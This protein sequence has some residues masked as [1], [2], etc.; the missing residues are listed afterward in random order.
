MPLNDFW[1]NFWH[2]TTPTPDFRKCRFNSKPILLFHFHFPWN[3]PW[4]HLIIFST[5]FTHSMSH[6]VFS[7]KFELSGHVRGCCYDFVTFLLQNHVPEGFRVWIM[8]QVNASFSNLDVGWNTIL[9]NLW[10]RVVGFQKFHQKSIKHIKINW[11][12]PTNVLFEHLFPQL[13]WWRQGVRVIVAC[14]YIHI[15]LQTLVPY[16]FSRFYRIYR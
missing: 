2:P 15:H 1:W 13:Y 12:G 10:S 6:A 9:F 8:V 4:L 16:L 3:R 5:G 7:P 14:G 11:Y